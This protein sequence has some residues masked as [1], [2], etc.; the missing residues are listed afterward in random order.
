MYIIVFILEMSQIVIFWHVRVLPKLLSPQGCRE[1]Q[2]VEK[3]CSRD[4]G[5]QLKLHGGP[6]NI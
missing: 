5:A 1:P 2:K 4:R 3:H 6:K